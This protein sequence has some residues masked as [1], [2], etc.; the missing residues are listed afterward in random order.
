[1]ESKDSEN[2]TA[3]EE[4]SSEVEWSSDEIS[5]FL[6]EGQTKEEKKLR[7]YLGSKGINYDAIEIKVH[8]RYSS[9]SRRK[10]Q[11]L[12]LSPTYTTID[13]LLLET[14]QDV[15]GHILNLLQKNANK[16]PSSKE[17]I[18]KAQKSSADAVRPALPMEFD[19]INVMNLG[20]IKVENDAP[21]FH[22]IVQIYPLGYKCTTNIPNCRAIEKRSMGLFE[23][24]IL[25]ADG[26][27]V[28][29]IKNLSNG[30]IYKSSTEKGVLK[31][32]EALGGYGGTNWAQ[33][34][35]NLEIEFL[36][37]GLEGSLQCKEYQYHEERGYP[38]QYSTQDELIEART[39]LL[40]NSERARRKARRDAI[41]LLSPEE[42]KRAE[43]LE[44][45][46]IQEEKES[47]KLEAIADRERKKATSVSSKAQKLQEMQ[48][49]KIKRE[50]EKSEKEE[51][52][53]IRKHEEKE[54]R[55]RAKVEEKY[56]NVYRRGMKNELKKLR[57]K[58]VLTV[59]DYV[60]N[61]EG[62]NVV[63]INQYWQSQ[64]KQF[65]TPIKGFPEGQSRPLMENI[66]INLDTADNA[67]LG[68]TSVHGDLNWNDAISIT[69]ELY[70]FRKELELNFP[71]TLT[72]VVQGLAIL[73]VKN[74]INIRSE[75]KLSSNTNTK[76]TI[77]EDENI[78]SSNS[79]SDSNSND[80]TVN[81]SKEKTCIENCDEDRILQA[82]AMA[83]RIHI[84]LVKALMNTL[85]SILEL[86]DREVDPEGGVRGGA[87]ARMVTPVHLPLNQLTWAE[88]ARQAIVAY[89]FSC[90]FNIPGTQVETLNSPFALRGGK[91]VQWRSS[92]NVMRRIRY[93]WYLRDQKPS[94]GKVADEQNQK[95]NDSNDVETKVVPSFY[96]ITDRLLKHLQ[97]KNSNLAVNIKSNPLPIEVSAFFKQPPVDCHYENEEQ[98]F[99]SLNEV[100]ENK[101]DEY[102]EVYCRCAL[103][104]QR[105]LTF[106]C[107]K[108]LIWDITADE[109]PEYFEVINRPVMLANVVMHLLHKSYDNVIDNLDT[110]DADESIYSMFYFEVQSVFN[111]CYTFNTEIQPIVAQTHKAQLTFF[112]L[113]QLWIFVETRPSIDKCDGGYCMLSSRV[114]ERDVEMRCGHCNGCFHLEALSDA[115]LS[116]NTD[117]V[118]VAQEL[119]DSPASEWVC[120][121]CMQEDSAFDSGVIGKQTKEESECF[122][123]ELGP[124]LSFP[125]QLNP[126]LNMDAAKLCADNLRFDSCIKAL[127]IL[128]NPAKTGIMPTTKSRDSRHDEYS[129]IADQDA[130]ASFLKQWTLQEHITI[131]KALMFCYTVQPKS[132][133]RIEHLQKSVE[134]LHA[135]ASGPVFKE[136]TFLSIVDDITG[137]V[138]SLKCRSMLDE[139]MGDESNHKRTIHSRIFTGRCSVCKGGT[140]PEDMLSDDEDEADEKDK[141]SKVNN[142]KNPMKMVILC[143]GCNSEAHLKCLNLAGVPSGDFF[144]AECKERKLARGDV[145][146]GT[147]DNINQYRDLV[148]EESLINRKIDKLA[149]EDGHEVLTSEEIPLPGVLDTS[150]IECVYCGSTEN[151]LCSP[152]VFSQTREEHEIYVASVKRADFVQIPDGRKVTFKINGRKIKPPPKEPSYFP[153][154]TSKDGA[155]LLK[156]LEKFAINPRNF[157]SHQLCALELFR[158]RHNTQRN[159]LRR[160][161]SKVVR[162][163]IGFSGLMLRPL[164]IDDR[165]REY[166]KFATLDDALF[167][168]RGPFGDD[169]K[170]QF[171][172][173]LEREKGNSTSSSE[174]TL[175]KTP[176]KT[177]SWRIVRDKSPGGVIY[178]LQYY[179]GP[180]KNEQ[181]LRIALAEAFPESIPNAA[182]SNNANSSY[183]S[184][185]LPSNT[186]IISQMSKD[187][188]NMTSVE[189]EDYEEAQLPTEISLLENKGSTVETFV[190]IDS[191]GVLSL[192][193]DGEEDNSLDFFDFGRKYYA[194]ALLNKYGKKIRLPKHSV[195]VTCQVHHT[196]SGDILA[197]TS[198]EEPHSDGVFY[199][200]TSVFF[201]SG[202][203]TISFV[204][205]GLNAE[206]ID[207]LMYQVHVQAKATRCGTI[208][209]M[210]K[211]NASNYTQRANRRI[212][213]P[214]IKRSTILSKIG[215]LHNEFES[216]RAA[217]LTFFSALPAGSLPEKL[218]DDR[219]SSKKNTVLEVRSE[220]LTEPIGWN[221]SVESAWYSTVT[222][223]RVPL[224]LMEATLLLQYYIAPKWF[225]DA[226]A[227]LLNALPNPHAALRMTTLSA[228]SLRIFCLDRAMLYDRVIEEPRSR[229]TDD[230]NSKVGKRAVFEP[231]YESKKRKVDTQ[232]QPTRTSGR[233]RNP[234]N[235]NFDDDDYEQ[236]FTETA[237]QPSSSSSNS[238]R[239]RKHVT[240]TD[241]FDQDEVAKAVKESLKDTEHMQIVEDENNNVDDIH[242]QGQDQN[243]EE[244]EGVFSSD[245][246][247]TDDDDDE[248]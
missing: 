206:N 45:K 6:I 201:R 99:N 186:S 116:G 240:S 25:E 76:V 82:V 117:V 86:Q 189:D 68:P 110:L 215:R 97:D 208:E 128:S 71:C 50:K 151:N 95:Q 27:P 80:E 40:A 143:D 115:Y 231:E 85:H 225:S 20:A 235:Y 3:L 236:D 38:H 60:D 30:E 133:K 181:D 168:C 226:E 67:I 101:S 238:G 48:E 96:G 24:E 14:K 130:A 104:L 114:I 156:D 124:S 47:E 52:D 100:I 244:E 200:S 126:R 142:Q 230:A 157:Y 93:R 64:A 182:N 125:W 31:K 37:E 1:M 29:Q 138:G 131:L 137:N 98:L 22:N 170:V 87:K 141:S 19:G 174:T 63:P 155:Q 7:S 112:R 232:Q 132:T 233:S 23:F 203:Y 11:P 5:S 146:D 46:R 217:L 41:K 221:D 190:E 150:S 239:K 77:K 21:E 222:S 176:T 135:A 26:G 246:D 56:R 164:G 187:A 139:I 136:G 188:P 18:Y 224:E 166:W 51:K 4:D 185:A 210:T 234:I 227:R 184:A 242:E 16:K 192:A 195:V 91:G 218:V 159:K 105:L 113:M 216:V 198:L 149:A 223:A 179:C 33:S 94:R 75:S 118:P 173:Q 191:E 28:F 36:I 209:A 180:S 165:G 72:K 49:A 103:V 13:G 241:D 183:K 123:D 32:L 90:L 61:E 213:I 199:F 245:S 127:T 65:A 153:Y 212:L 70:I 214:R 248:I 178:Q 73:D 140:F 219:K 175:K 69:N 202:Y 196:T 108:N 81:V 89:C 229:R 177:C 92:R 152:M 148:L 34:F 247:N 35:F 57:N 163:A 121:Y 53:K 106:S 197:N 220:N 120:P 59:L 237:Q 66:L 109:V 39:A 44:L 169:D 228:V 194:I 15:A 134:Q 10:D 171:N 158:A 111:N 74:S 154:V 84:Q 107:S 193:P 161:Y 83:D 88:L 79:N 55:D 119:V 129:E 147:F 122:V 42:Q 205:E 12:T 207:P 144:C 62:A 160:E 204:V 8:V 17:D 9:K 78:R 145:E 167:I 43:N 172:E 58:S 243:S 162:T 102:K 2:T 54:A 211:L